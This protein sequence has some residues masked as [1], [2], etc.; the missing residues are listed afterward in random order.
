MVTY[1]TAKEMTGNKGRDGND[2]QQM[3]PPKLNPGTLQFSSLTQISE[4]AL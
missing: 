3:S 2:M 4:E 1:W